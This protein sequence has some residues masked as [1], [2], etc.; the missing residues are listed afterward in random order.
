[1]SIECIGPQLLL[2]GSGGRLPSQLLHS[3]TILPTI[4]SPIPST[5]SVNS[6]DVPR[7]KG[8]SPLLCCEMNL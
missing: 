7:R 8:V 3:A 5:L 4:P 2:T 6:R 1:M